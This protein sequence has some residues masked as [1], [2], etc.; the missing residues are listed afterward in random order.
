MNPILFTGSCFIDNR[1]SLLYN[2]IFDFERIK[3]CY[4][5][6]NNITNPIRAWQGHK[7]ERRWFIAILGDF[8]ITLI[9]IDNWIAPSKYLNKNEF[10]LNSNSMDILQIPPGYIS[11]IESLSQSAKLLVMSDYHFNEIEDDYRFEKNYFNI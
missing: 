10:T 11:S 6:E 4:I 9:K 7:I 1:G 2:N 8:K 3:R 5:I